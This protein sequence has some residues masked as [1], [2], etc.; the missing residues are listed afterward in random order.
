MMLITSPTRLVP[1]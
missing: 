1:N